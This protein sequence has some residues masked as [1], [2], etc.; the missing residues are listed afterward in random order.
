MGTPHQGS[1]GVQMAQV[2]VNVASIFVSTNDEILKHLRENSEWLQ[3]NIGQYAPISG[4]FL[5]KFAHET[6][7]TPTVAGST[8]M[9]RESAV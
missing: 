6:L 8:I 9:V 3:Q 7:P 1:N 4:H 2:V 5:T